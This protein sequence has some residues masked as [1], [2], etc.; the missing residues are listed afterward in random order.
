MHAYTIGTTGKIEFSLASATVLLAH[1]NRVT[2]ISLSRTFSVA[3]SGDG[4]GIIVI[5]DLNRY[6]CT[7]C[8]IN[9][10]FTYLSTE[11]KIYI[12]VIYMSHSYLFLF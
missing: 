4:S 7:I 6:I 3:C 2:V 1:R 12:F 10:N 8:S 5:W 11:R 9:I